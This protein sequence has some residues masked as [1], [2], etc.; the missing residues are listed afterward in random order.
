MGAD[1]LNLSGR[2]ASS[3]FGVVELS[4]LTS[5]VLDYSSTQTYFGESLAVLGFVVGCVV[6]EFWPRRTT[7]QTKTMKSNSTIRSL[8]QN[9]AQ[10]GTSEH[11]MG[12][13]A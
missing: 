3:E 13:Q 1:N 5:R 6:L 7:P 2:V 8:R 4:V 10:C 11:S 12:T 9:A